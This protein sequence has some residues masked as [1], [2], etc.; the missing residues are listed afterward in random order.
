[1]S[2]LTFSDDPLPL[3]TTCSPL[4]E[5]TALAVGLLPVIGAVMLPVGFI[6]TTRA[7]PFPAVHDKVTELEVAALKLMFDACVDGAEPD[8][9]MTEAHVVPT[10][11][12][13]TTV[14]GELVAEPCRN[15]IALIASVPL[16]VV[17]LTS[18]V[19]AKASLAGIPLGMTH[20]DTGSA[21]VPVTMVY[22]STMR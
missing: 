17:L 16:V 12:A 5:Y 20:M 11:M 13:S 22:F 18:G 3:Y 10:R 8:A 19:P 9:G 14:C 2:P 15:P 6:F 21:V 4:P 1:M 7:S